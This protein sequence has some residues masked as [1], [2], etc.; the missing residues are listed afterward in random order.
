M[1]PFAKQLERAK[2]LIDHAEAGPPHVVDQI[3]AAARDTAGHAAVAGVVLR[4][5]QPNRGWQE[6]QQPSTRTHQ[7]Y[8][9]AGLI[10]CAPCC[11][12]R[13]GGPQPA[14][15]RLPLRR[16][17][18]TR[19]VLIVRNPPPDEDD[20][21]DLCGERDVSR[22]VPFVLSYGPT[23]VAGDVCMGCAGVLRIDGAAA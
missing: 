16:L 11:H 3:Q 1:T 19:C 8:V 7:L 5:T 20:R 12:L 15:A 13:R 2:W 10:D 23:L 9:V 4:A 22:F 14:F 18:C 17:D 6:L 21:C